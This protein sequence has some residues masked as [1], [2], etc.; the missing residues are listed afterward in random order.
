M[1][2]YATCAKSWATSSATS[3]AACGALAMDW[4]HLMLLLRRVRGEARTTVSRTLWNVP[5]GLQLSVIYALLLAA[6]LTML[7]WALYT[8]LDSFLVRNTADHLQQSADNALH[9][10]VVDFRPVADPVA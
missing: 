4:N 8:Q 1:C 6:T 10:A 7:G 2:I 5:V 3:S 9:G